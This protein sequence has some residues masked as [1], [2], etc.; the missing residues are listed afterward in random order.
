MTTRKPKAWNEEFAKF[1]ESPSRETL[2]DLLKH[3]VGE[4][5][6]LDFKLEWPEKSAVAKHVLAIANSGGGCIVF[7]IE[8]G[9]MEPKGLV[10][11]KDAA[12][13]FQELEKYVPEQLRE[14][15]EAPTFR[16]DVSEYPKLQGRTFQ[17]LFI[18]G[19][20]ARV[21]FVAAADGIAIRNAAI[22]VRKGTES[23][24]ASYEDLQR[25][26]NRRLETGV[27]STAELDIRDHLMQLQVL[28]RQLAPTRDKKS[29]LSL[30]LGEITRT[31]FG[32]ESEPNPNYPEE[33]L[34]AFVA[35]AILMKKSRIL[36]V[37]DVYRSSA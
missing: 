27:S 2:R 12:A 25:L 7:G 31:M 17:V 14:Q 29:P 33:E 23:V 16:Y 30:G 5:D 8:D 21:P 37:L 4:L 34:D 6:E 11:P 22:Y 24:E 35:R 28:Y 15:L 3:S 9:T 10:E 13:V 26:I 32:I 36:D 19:D 18:P 20:A 1:F